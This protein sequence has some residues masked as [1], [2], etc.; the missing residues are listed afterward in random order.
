[1]TS[2]SILAGRIVDDHLHTN[3]D[4]CNRDCHA[5]DD[6]NRGR[7]SIFINNNSVICLFVC[8]FVCFVALRPKSTA[9]VMA[10]L[11]VY[12]TTL[13]SWAGLN[14]QLTSTLCTHFRL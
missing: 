1:M 14:K 12:L 8:L 9:M 7:T 13:L 2:L 4:I 3:G 11:S 6:F 5:I 10:G